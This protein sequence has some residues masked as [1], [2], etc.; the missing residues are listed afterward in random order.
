MMGDSLT[1]CPVS[2]VLGTPSKYLHRKCSLKKITGSKKN[3]TSQADI[4][5]FVRALR[6]SNVQSE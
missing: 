1:P 2:P 6:L 4:E 3:I 5:F